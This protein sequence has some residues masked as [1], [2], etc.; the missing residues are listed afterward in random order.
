LAVNDPGWS[1]VWRDAIWGLIPGFAARR[2][3]RVPGIRGMGSVFVSFVVAGVL[4]GVILAFIDLG[5]PNGGPSSELCIAI[6]CGIGV[7]SI[8]AVSVLR[9]RP[10]DASS[11]EMVAS[12]Y[13]KNLFLKVAFAQV[14]S[15]SAFVLTFLSVRHAVYWVGL[16][17][18][19]L[20]F[21]VGAP[22]RADVERRQNEIRLSRSP[23]DLLDALQ[24]V[25]STR[26]G[27]PWPRRS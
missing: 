25:P 8:G 17:W 1:G 4:Y 18:S 23:L 13:R 9:K 10:L 24:S 27:Q 6:V 2:A 15:L 20:A 12:A 21:A 26:P 7:A 14:P 5:R 19:F 16:A 3:R 11:A 22:T